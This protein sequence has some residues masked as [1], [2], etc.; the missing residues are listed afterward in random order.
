MEET[1]ASAH[2]HR[3][4][5]TPD[6]LWLNIGPA[7]WKEGVKKKEKH[8]IP[9]FSCQSN[10]PHPLHQQPWQT[11]THRNWH[12]KRRT[13]PCIITSPCFFTNFFTMVAPP[14]YEAVV[15]FLP[16][17]KF[18]VQTTK[19]NNTKLS[20]GLICCQKKQKKKTAW[21]MMLPEILI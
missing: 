6:M 4:R 15:S 10:T 5:P 3:E 19:A 2:R 16:L 12:G 14:R 13:Y 21:R 18:F 8:Q 9:W 17:Q 7:V 1:H 20:W 11:D